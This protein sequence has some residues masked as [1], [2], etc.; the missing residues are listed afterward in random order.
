MDSTNSLTGIESEFTKEQD[1]II[2]IMVHN[3][4]YIV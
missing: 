3:M 1:D 4:H 2:T